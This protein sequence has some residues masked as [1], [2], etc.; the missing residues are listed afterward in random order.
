MRATAEPL[1]GNK[2]KL[3]VELDEAEVE[4]AVEG[5][6]RRMA[7]EVRIPGFRPGKVPRRLL[8]AR[9]GRETLR[10]EALQEAIPNYYAQALEDTSVDAI[11]PPELDITSGREEGAVVFDAVVEVRPIVSVAGYDGLE[12][13]LPSL[14]VATEEVDDQLDRLRN[15]DPSARLE[16]VERPIRAGDHVRIDLSATR[17]GEPVPGLSV[18]DT[19][20]EVG[21][22]D[23]L[24]GLD[25]ALQGSKVGDI[26]EFE[27]TVPGDE[28]PLSARA[29]VKEVSEKV[30]PEADDAWAAENSEFETL[31][32][33]REGLRSRL[34]ELKKARARLLLRER[35]LEALVAL[36]PDE[37]PE[38]LVDAEIDER[39][40]DLGHRLEAQ[41]IS[42]QQY[43]EAIGTDRDGLVAQ[44][45]PAAVDAVKADLALRGVAEAEAI[46][47]TDEDVDKEIA[48]I[49][50][51]LGESDASVRDRLERAGRLAAVRSELRKAKALTWLEEHVG[52]VDDNG[53]PIDR[54]ELETGD[55][56]AEIAPV[57]EGNVEQ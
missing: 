47:A 30:L 39:L 42:A 7:R 51:R 26:V 6:C 48:E 8:E 52:T 23:L 2:V 9:I 1:E 57:T 5:T 49:A 20:Y 35:A 13:T 54:A 27:T 56:A 25:P 36:V 4:Q 12:V 29:L 33:L 34:T 31:D 53:R 45:R 41:R 14:E 10:L 55:R 43:L 32:E 44:L 46:E 21:G 22:Q 37:P 17:E 18:Q 19:V 40:H 24:P 16:Q 28:T 3:S 15:A 38:A 50:Q 11:A